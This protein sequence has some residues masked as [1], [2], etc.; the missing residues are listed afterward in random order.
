MIADESAASLLMKAAPAFVDCV[1]GEAGA[2]HGDA[3]L[4]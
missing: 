3:R 4:L 1:G 2:T